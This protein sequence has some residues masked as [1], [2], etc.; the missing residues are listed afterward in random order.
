MSE[1]P[2]S[3]YRFRSTYALLDGFQELEKQELYFAPFD[4]LNDPMEG[5]QRFFWKGDEVAW[6]CFFRNYV[7]SLTDAAITVIIGI[8]DDS[9]RDYIRPHLF[10]EDMATEKLCGLHRE[11]YAEVAKNKHL[12][13]LV[14]HLSCF[15][16]ELN[17]EQLIEFIGMVH[18]Q[19][20]IIIFEKF[21]EHSFFNESM[22]V[23]FRESLEERIHDLRFLETTIAA[24]ESE[25]QFESI[26]SIL[27]DIT[28]K[29]RD[30]ILLIAESNQIEEKGEGWHNLVNEFNSNS[31]RV[32]YLLA[33]VGEL[34]E[35]VNEEIN[36]ELLANGYFDESQKVRNALTSLVENNKRDKGKQIQRNVWIELSL[37]FPELFLDKITE[38]VHPLL[39]AVSF[40]EE[41]TNAAMWGYYGDGHKGVALKFKV[42][43]L[44]EVG[45]LN[46]ETARN[47]FH[48][49]HYQK[50]RPL[51]DFFRTLGGRLTSPQVVKWLT[52]SNGVTSDCIEAYRDGEE[53]RKDYWDKLYKIGCIKLPDWE[54]EAEYR[55]LSDDFFDRLDSLEKRKT[56]YAFTDL[57]G[58]V[59]GA[60]TS[61]ADRIKI[62][63]IIDAK[64]Q[65]TRRKDFKFYQAEYDEKTG[66]ME[67]VELTQ[68]KISVNSAA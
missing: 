24:A 67:C 4:E 53:W 23:F 19:F 65:K 17:R 33:Q 1:V 60:K 22:R 26:I 34:I 12:K 15:W 37:L 68:L 27:F 44:N 3:L 36:F 8:G 29:N 50:E 30:Q 46:L 28:R 41:A 48:E 25:E 56:R 66:S 62:M 2:T 63:K 64:C 13:M 43:P 58:I 45:T 42:T 54:H 16:N 59:F 20:L 9:L 14:Q 49:V 52:D 61:K 40:S 5:V 32:D 6:N 57:E 11:V 35:G 10:E 38:Y 31:L 21:Y 39:H 7:R 55:L 47:R 51:I 18:A